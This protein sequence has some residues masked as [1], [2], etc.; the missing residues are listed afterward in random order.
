MLL[1]HGDQAAAL[2]AFAAAV[3]KQPDVPL[4]SETLDRVQTQQHTGAAAPT[5]IP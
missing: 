3:A 5:H 2:E 4:F 1:N